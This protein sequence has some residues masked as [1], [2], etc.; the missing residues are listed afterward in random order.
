MLILLSPA[1]RLNMVQTT[2]TLPTELP[3]YLSKAEVIM[4]ILKKMKPAEISTLM[5]IN[6]QL[7]RLNYE[8]FQLWHPEFSEANAKAALLSFD[9]DVYDGMQ[10]GSWPDEDLIY[11]QDR[12]RILSGLYG[13][14][15]PMDLIQAYRLEMGTPLP[16]R[17]KKNLYAFWGD[18][19]T[20]T[21]KRT[22]KEGNHDVLL[23]L[24]SVEYFKAVQSKK[25][26]TRI[27]APAF[28]EFHEGNY[29]MFSIF[30]KRARG[31]MTRWI[32]QHRIENPEDIIAFN[33]D[34]YEFNPGLSTTDVPVFTRG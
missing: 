3:E 6:P 16:V 4:K 19:I 5:D 17:S 20:A 9:G 13:I 29:K 10:A 2:H 24:A 15:K 21:V 23:N 26:K 12:I 27:I 7:A 31:M 32:I 22:I 25:L 1:K 14:L 30:G 33:E 34:G 28:R 8:R 18:A 11:A